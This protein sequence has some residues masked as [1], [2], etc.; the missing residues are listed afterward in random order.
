MNPEEADQAFAQM[1]G[2]IGSALASMQGGMLGLERYEY[3][4]V[5]IDD[6]NAYARDRWRVVP[7]PPVQEVKVTLGQMA[8]GPAVFLMERQ[9]LTDDA[10]LGQLAASA[11]PGEPG[12]GRDA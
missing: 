3:A 7:V 8:P 1:M 9:L 10:D 6:L 12:G 5:P 4:M 11:G 2:M